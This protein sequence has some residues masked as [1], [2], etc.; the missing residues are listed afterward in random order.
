MNSKRT[1]PI[2]ILVTTILFSACR[3]PEIKENIAST[4]FISSKP[5]SEKYVI[6]KKESVIIWKAT[7]QF[8]LGAGH[9]GYVDIANGELMVD[10]GQLTGGLVEVDMNTIADERHGRD[11]NLVNH[12]KNADFFEVEKFSTSVFTITKVEPATGENVKVTGL[13]TIKGIT[14]LVDFIANIEVK[15]GVVNANGKLTIDRTRWDVRYKSGKFFDNL[16][17]ETISDNVEFEVKIV[18]RR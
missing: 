2:A 4:S 5:S 11:N 3:G 7:M 15:G 9:F 14:N 16:A 12:L 10:K 1:F 6:D 8:T 18:A 13:L 17:D